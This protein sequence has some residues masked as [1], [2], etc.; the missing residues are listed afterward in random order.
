MQVAKIKQEHE[1]FFPIKAGWYF[2]VVM[3]ADNIAQL[4][5]AN[6]HAH[7]IAT[8]FLNFYEWK[9]STWL[10]SVNEH[11]GSVV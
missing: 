7:N 5:D 8:K 6:G 2:K 4:E 1:D 11:Y 3:A 10:D 9:L